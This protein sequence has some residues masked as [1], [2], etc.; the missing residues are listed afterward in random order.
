MFISLYASINSNKQTELEQRRA[1]VMAKGLPKCK[2]IDGVK[3][4]ILVSSGKGGV[5]KSTTAGTTI[6][7]LL[8]VRFSKHYKFQ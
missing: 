5:G 4:I 8:T 6:I 2:P 1:Q 3:E 7:P